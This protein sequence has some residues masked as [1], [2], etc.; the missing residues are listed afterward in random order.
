MLT[1]YSLSFGHYI[2]YYSPRILPMLFNLF[3]LFV[4]EHAI[5]IS[6]VEHPITAEDWPLLAHL[7]I[8]IFVL[9][10]FS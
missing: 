10:L 5:N 4:I 9:I 7:I 2:W 1:N 6:S 3:F 8:S